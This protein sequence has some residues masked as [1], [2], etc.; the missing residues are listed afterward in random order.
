MK[1]SDS[2]GVL[3]CRGV[4]VWDSTQNHSVFDAMFSRGHL[5]GMEA[6]A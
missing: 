2:H 4:G 1:I 5:V 3:V 6:G